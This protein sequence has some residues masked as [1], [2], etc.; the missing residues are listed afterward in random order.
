MQLDSFDI[1][2]ELLNWDLSIGRGVAVARINDYPVI[3]S[4]DYQLLETTDMARFHLYDEYFEGMNTL[5]MT[6][7]DSQG[8]YSHWLSLAIEICLVEVSNGVF[9]DEYEPRPDPIG[10]YRNHVVR[11]LDQLRVLEVLVRSFEVGERFRWDEIPK[12]EGL[13]TERRDFACL[14]I[15]FDQVEWDRKHSS[16]TEDG[17]YRWLKQAAVDRVEQ[18]RL[19]NQQNL[20][21]YKI[22]GV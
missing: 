21:K 16:L 22:I 13:S 20:A 9:F 12:V 18:V 1:G 15:G 11:A 7:G 19:Q 17:G 4:R 3:V 5:W 8:E 6:T 10:D 14:H 2:C